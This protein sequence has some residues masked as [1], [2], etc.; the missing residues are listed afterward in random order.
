[1]KKTRE[2]LRRRRHVRARQKVVGTPE[3][4]RLAARRTA[5]HIHVQIVDDTAGITLAAA[6]T[7]CKTYRAD[8][9]KNFTGVAIA[10]TIGAE[11]AQKAKE[12]GVSLVVFDCCGGKYH[13][14]LK[15]LADSA[16]EAGLSF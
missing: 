5:R 12:K 11:I 4:P 6:T 7:D 8:G 14:A 9:R 10:K 1:M 13:G 16:R 2:Q 3:R 15:A